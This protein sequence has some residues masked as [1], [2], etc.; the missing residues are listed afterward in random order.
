MSSDQI[1]SVQV[2]AILDSIALETMEVFTLSIELTGNQLPANLSVPLYNRTDV[3][4]ADAT[5]KCL[6]LLVFITYFVF[7]VH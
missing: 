6:S 3:F 2:L 7:T 4:I 1:G 5:S